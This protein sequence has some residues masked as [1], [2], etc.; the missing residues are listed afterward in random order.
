[1]MLLWRV[2]GNNII[3]HDLVSGFSH[4]IHADDFY[5][6][7]FSKRSGTQLNDYKIN[8]ESTVLS[9]FDDKMAKKYTFD[10]ETFSS[11]FNDDD[12]WEEE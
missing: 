10:I 1:M 2:R 3:F 4:K 6:F 5:N 8:K 12:D 11:M 7:D 9:F